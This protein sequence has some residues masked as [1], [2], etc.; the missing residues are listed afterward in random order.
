METTKSKYSRIAS[1]GNTAESVLCTQASVRVCLETYFQKQIDTIQRIYGKKSDI[2]IRF[3]DGTTTR[4]QNKDGNILS[5]GWS[6]DRR[7]AIKLTNDSRL[8]TLLR[9]ICLK[10]GFSRPRIPSSLSQEILTQCVLGED[11][12]Y[13][14]QYVTHT[15][16]N[17]ETGEILTLSICSAKS[18]LDN[19]R[20]ELYPTMRS[21][22]TCV[23]LSPCVY[24]QRKG[25][26][27]KDSRPDDIQTKLH[28]TIKTQDLYTRTF[29]SRMG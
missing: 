23:H 15:T 20:K 28:F 13:A 22:R 18:F 4:I 6:V 10:R 24:L 29:V 21:K 14:P 25:G 26:G 8:H 9:S 11:A 19:L 17:K 12:E 5:R 7:P 1:N 27:K 16:S 3:C 2:V